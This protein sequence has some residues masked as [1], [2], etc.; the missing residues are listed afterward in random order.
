MRVYGEF[1]QILSKIAQQIN[2]L[3]DRKK[4][5]LVRNPEDPSSWDQVFDDS[6]LA[7]DIPQVKQ[8]GK[9][10]ELGLM[11]VQGVYLAAMKRAHREAYK[12]TPRRRVHTDNV[13]K[14]IGDVQGWLQADLVD[15]L[16]G[17]IRK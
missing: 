6:F 1:V 13:F 15:Y 10:F 5:D 12:T 4:F 17:M 7:Q 9:S 3:A 2:N 16:Q 8:N 11:H 14:G